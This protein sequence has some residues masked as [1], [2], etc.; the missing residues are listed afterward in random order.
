MSEE[1]DIQK[2]QR[3]NLH[4]CA[5]VEKHVVQRDKAWAGPLQGDQD[6]VK[7]YLV[8]VCRWCLRPTWLEAT[9]KCLTGRN[10]PDLMRVMAS[11]MPPEFPK[12]WY[13]KRKLR[14]Q[15]EPIVEVTVDE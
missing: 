12:S 11:E 2:A 8:T 4:L 3:R 1:S 10:V 15:D 13:S 6:A 7:T 9:M 14:A 5:K